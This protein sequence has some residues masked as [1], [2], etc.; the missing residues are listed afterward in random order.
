MRLLTDLLHF[1]RSKLFGVPYFCHFYVTS[2]CDLR[3]KQCSFPE[4]FRRLDTKNRG[5]LNLQEIGI[6]ADRLRRIGVHNVLLSGGEPFS[7][8]D[9]ADIVRILIQNKLSVRIVTNGGSL[10]TE[11]RLQEVIDAGI[12]ALQVS[13]DSLNPDLH[14]EIAQVKGT[15]E[16]AK[17]TLEYASH[18]LTNGMVCALTVVSA[19]NINELPEIARYVTSIG[20]YSIF[21]PV[22]LASDKDEVGMLGMNDYREMRIGNEKNSVVER[23]Y[24]E[25]LQMKKNGYNI[26]SSNRFLKNSA[27]YLSSRQRRWVCDAYRYYLTICPHGEVLPCLR[28]E[29]CEWLERLNILDDTFIEKYTSGDMKHNAQAYRERCPGC[30]LSC[31]REMSYLLRYPSV[32]LEMSG[33]IGRKLIRKTLRQPQLRGKRN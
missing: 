6:L 1:T 25:L 8:K 5:V 9:L 20:A 15:W 27:A 3:C 29:D 16:K 17:R 4:D 28:F 14:D 11:K 26:L 22:H 31:Y 7:R 2:Y 33:F 30:V 12:D 10:V 23:V 18:N 32:F 24:H 21:Q 13:F 19:Y